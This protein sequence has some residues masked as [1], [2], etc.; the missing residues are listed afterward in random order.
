[1]DQDLIV[2]SLGVRGPTPMQVVPNSQRCVW[3]GPP[4]EQLMPQPE[5]SDAVLGG[6]KVHSSAVAILHFFPARVCNL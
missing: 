3:C 1:M 4:G 5:L 2:H 6:S